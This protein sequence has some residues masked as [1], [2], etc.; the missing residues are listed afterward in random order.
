MTGLIAVYGAN[1]GFTVKQQ[2]P[3]GEV[4]VMTRREIAKWLSRRPEVLTAEHIDGIYDHARRS[5]TWTTSG[6]APR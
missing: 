3:G 1:G 4:V 2:P 5:T 6:R